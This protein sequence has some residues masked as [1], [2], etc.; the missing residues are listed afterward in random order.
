LEKNV[1]DY[2][3]PSKKIIRA[4]LE[5]SVRGL[6]N[7]SKW[8][9]HHINEAYTMGNHVKLYLKLIYKVFPPHLSTYFIYC[10]VIRLNCEIKSKYLVHA[11]IAQGFVYA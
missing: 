8:I 6:P 3:L 1:A 9:F 7:D 5:R 2:R 4:Y 11:R 10:Y